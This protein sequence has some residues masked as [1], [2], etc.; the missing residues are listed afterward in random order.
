[1]NVYV[2]DI[3]KLLKIQPTAAERVRDLM[4]EGGLDFSE[5]TPDEFE[6]AAWTA[7]QK[8]ITVKQGDRR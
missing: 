2:R 3:S 5:C 1:M 7:L 4:E 6:A 8:M